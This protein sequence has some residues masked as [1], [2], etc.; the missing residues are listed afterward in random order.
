ML[1]GVPKDLEIRLLRQ[2]IFPNTKLATD[3]S[4]EGQLFHP[5]KYIL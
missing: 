1:Y 4:P 5:F 3:N 2:S